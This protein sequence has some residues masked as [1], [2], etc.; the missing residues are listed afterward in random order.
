MLV[1]N[2]KYFLYEKY[3]KLFCLVPKEKYLAPLRI[4]YPFIKSFVNPFADIAWTYFVSSF[5]SF[6]TNTCF[7]LSELILLLKPDGLLSKSV[8]FT[9][10]AISL[11]LAKF[12]CFNLADVKLLNSGVVIYLSWLW[13]VIFVF[14]FINF[15]VL[16]SFFTKLLTLGLLFS[17][18]LRAVLVAKLVI[19]GISPSTSSILAS[20]VV[21]VT[22]LVMPGILSSVFFILALYIYSSTT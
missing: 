5:N 7:V 11:L 20:R 9:K 13:I 14:H 12:V 10:L 1:K 2:L 16:V 6:S 19:L 3:I 18:A 8:L 22:K 15:G 21:L 4:V 17:T